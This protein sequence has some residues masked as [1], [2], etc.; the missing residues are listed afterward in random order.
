M[1]LIV[2]FLRRLPSGRPLVTRICAEMLGSFR[3]GCR[4][5]ADHLVERR[6]QQ[7][8]VMHVGSA[9]DDRQRDATPVD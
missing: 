7:L 4:S 9:R 3:T 1:G 8:H 2:A 6:R 5:G